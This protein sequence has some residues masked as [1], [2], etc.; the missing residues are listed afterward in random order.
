MAVLAT[1]GFEVE[2]QPQGDG[3]SWVVSAVP[4]ASVRVEAV[5]LRMEEIA[6]KYSGEYI[7]RGGL[8]P[9][10]GPDRADD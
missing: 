3:D 2:L 1:E 4:H 9:I 8:W 5:S 7:G 10:G 6:T